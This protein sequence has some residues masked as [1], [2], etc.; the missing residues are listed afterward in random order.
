MLATGTATVFRGD[1]VRSAT[2]GAYACAGGATTAFVA[3]ALIWGC[4]AVTVGA[5]GFAVHQRYTLAR[6]L[7]WQCDELPVLSRFTSVGSVATTE[8]EAREFRPSLY[9]LRTGVIRSLRVPPY[10]FSPQTTTHFWTSLTLNLFGY[11][12]IAGRLMPLVFGLIAI[13]G[14]AWATWLC[15]RS[16]P[17]TCVAA[18]IVGFSP[19]AM[20][21]SAQSRGYGEAIALLPLML[22][23]LELWRRKSSSWVRFA[24]VAILTM[25]LSLTVYTLW[26]YW[27]FPVLVMALVVLP[28]LVPNVV[29]RASARAMLVGLFVLMCLWMG[30]FT[31]ER[32]KTL[33]FASTYGVSFKSWTELGSFLQLFV[34]RL[35]PV[36]IVTIP[37]MIVGA[38]RLHR[39]SIGW[40]GAAMLAGIALPIAFGILN[41][42]PGHIRNM[43]YLL[44]PLAILAGVGFGAAIHVLS[45]TRGE[46]AVGVLSLV[47]IV[48]ITATSSAALGDKAYQF[49]LPDWG[50]VVR[51]V[52]ATA[53]TAGPRF[54]CPCAANHWQINWYRDRSDDAAI[55]SLAFG[56][57]V[58]IVMGAQLNDAGEAVIY[59]HNKRLDGVRA[60]VLPDYLARVGPSHVQAGVELRRWRGTKVRLADLPVGG[61]PVIVLAKLDH[62]PSVGQWGKFLGDAGAFDAGVVVFKERFLED[63]Q[64]H[65]MIIP[66]DFAEQADQFLRKEL[67]ATNG[68]LSWIKLSPL[69]E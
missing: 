25:Q 5:G 1:D 47:A 62:G 46:V 8:V 12:M 13:I 35:I 34:E 58:E 63:M 18:L 53:K 6:D 19:A 24:F 49:L 39:S 37:L 32:W 45:R 3:R 56:E 57:S 20:A 26:V 33:T 65:S 64:L 68:D 16:I 50:A 11:G 40:W 41:G 66:A 55:G 52:D 23:A 36:P 17:A 38:C 4:V 27:V 7:S 60:E 44:G 42:S 14:V 10:I 21:Y 29:E 54:F 15:V 59:R 30:V 69:S 43:V 67:G 9:S 61:A 48:G 22:V 31:A 28:R 2:D 51:S